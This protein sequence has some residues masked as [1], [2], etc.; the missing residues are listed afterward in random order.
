MNRQQHTEVPFVA[1]QRYSAGDITAL[2]T[3][4]LAP[5]ADASVS[6]PAASE[7][8]FNLISE[9]P[10]LADAVLHLKSPSG[11][12]SNRALACRSLLTSWR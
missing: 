6:L 8:H 2:V 3:V 9:W 1:G 11:V 12:L 5:P 4:D 10:L 7:A